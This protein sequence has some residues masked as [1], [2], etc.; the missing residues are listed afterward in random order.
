M[1]FGFVAYRKGELRAEKNRRDEDLEQVVGER[2]LAALEHMADELQDPAADEQHAEPDPALSRAL[3]GDS[4]SRPNKN[5][6][7]QKHSERERHVKQEVVEQHRRSEQHCGADRDAAELDAR[8]GKRDEERQHD[9]RHAYEVSSLVARVLV[10]CRVKPHLLFESFHVEAPGALL[11]SATNTHKP[12][13]PSFL[14]WYIAMSALASST[15][16][17][18]PSC[19]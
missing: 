2:G 3:F 9:R 6:S 18:F 8:P 5:A 15:A 4:F 10:V 13:R 17:S 16:T 12:L 11:M 19:G 7:N 14:T 1:K